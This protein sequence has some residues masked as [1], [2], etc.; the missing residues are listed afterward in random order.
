MLPEMSHRETSDKLHKSRE[1]T[2][3]DLIRDGCVHSA[4]DIPAQPGMQVRRTNISK[5]N[6]PSNLEVNFPED[7]KYTV[8]RNASPL[9]A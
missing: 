3:A 1:Q 9:R 4:I 2:S 6:I 8:I 7:G 5:G